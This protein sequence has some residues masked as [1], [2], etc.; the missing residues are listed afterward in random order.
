[1]ARGSSVAIATSELGHAML[2]AGCVDMVAS[3]THGDKRSLM[4]VRDWLLEMG[5][6]EH[7]EL[8]TRENA[9][10]LLAGQSMAPVPP[11]KIKRGMRERLRELV[12]GRPRGV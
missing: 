9:R 2:A 12:L 6:S 11:L 8:L 7:A 10:R 3:D 1:M 4:A 5:A